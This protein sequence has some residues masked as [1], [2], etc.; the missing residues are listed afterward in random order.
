MDVTNGHDSVTLARES[1]TGRHLRR[2]RQ[3]VLAAARGAGLTVQ[4]SSHLVLAVNEA[5]TNAVKHAG[6]GGEL[7]VI[8]DDDRALIAVITDRGPGLPCPPAPTRPDVE[9]PGG[10][11]LW[12][13]QQVC[14][15]VEVQSG[16]TGTRV[17]LEMDLHSG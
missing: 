5:A 8:Q 2:L 14:D 9:S 1:F 4:R 3:L 10:R 12:L 7:E 11:G 17:R 16:R 6:G 15:R 13:I